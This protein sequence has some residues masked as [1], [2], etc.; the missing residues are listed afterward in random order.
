MYDGGSMTALMIG[1]Y[2]DSTPPPPR[3]IS[4]SNQL[5]FNFKSNGFVTSSGF[6]FQYNAASRYFVFRA[7]KK[8][9]FFKA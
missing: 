8:L 4:S 9:E 1:E 2:C 5:F 3:Q 7:K 6:K